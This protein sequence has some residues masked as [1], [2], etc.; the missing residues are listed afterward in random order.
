[1]IAAALLVLFLFLTVINTSNSSLM[2]SSSLVLVSSIN[3]QKSIRDTRSS[4]L[5][6]SF[7]N[8][9]SLK[10]KL[11]N[12]ISFVNAISE[13]KFGGVKNLKDVINKAKVLKDRKNPV[14]QKDSN[15]LIEPIFETVI[16]F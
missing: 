3:G 2:L 7:K 4:A 10:R 9:I 14:N 12:P 1:M 11:T 13:P 5:P 6:L 16:E 8:L 15:N